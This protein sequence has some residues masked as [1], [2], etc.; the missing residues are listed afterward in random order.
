MQG[1][2]STKL[3]SEKW[4]VKG[5]DLSGGVAAGLDRRGCTRGLTVLSSLLLSSPEVLRDILPGRDQNQKNTSQLTSVWRQL[6]ANM[7]LAMSYL[8][9]VSGVSSH[10]GIDI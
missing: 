2:S 5:T 3:S 9:Q 4:E 7:R 8:E 10:Q 1:I 6:S